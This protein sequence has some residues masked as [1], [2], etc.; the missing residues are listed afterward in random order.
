MH[1]VEKF[2]C[3][4]GCKFS[5]YATWWIRQSVTRALPDQARPIRLPA[6]IVQQ[7]HR[8]AP[9]QRDLTERLHKEPRHEELAQALDM[10]PEQI[11]TLLY[12]QRET[13]S[14]DQKIRDDRVSVL[15]DLVCW[16][17]PAGSRDDVA[18]RRFRREVDSQLTTLPPREQR[19]I[20]LRYGLVDGVSRERIR[21][22]EERTL[23]KLREP[24]EPSPVVGRVLNLRTGQAPDECALAVAM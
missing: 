11:L 20:R 12:Y 9:A 3:T 24:T 17:E 1:A 18:Q 23:D 5:T 2:D 13:V 8:L 16:R 4:P 15:A 10:S 22:I 19:V 7:L 21:Q 6:R 14:P